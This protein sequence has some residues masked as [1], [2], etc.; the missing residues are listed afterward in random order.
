[1]F[2]VPWH[3]F[4]RRSHRELTV[5]IN[6]LTKVTVKTFDIIELKNLTHP[7]LFNGTVYFPERAT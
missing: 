3:P 1:M 6:K 4:I 7:T 2:A 5:L